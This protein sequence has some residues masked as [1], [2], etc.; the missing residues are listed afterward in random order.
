MPGRRPYANSLFYLHDDQVIEGTL[1][2]FVNLTTLNS[3]F[4]SQQ[5]GSEKLHRN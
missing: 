1:F 2:Y 3:Y 5:L 4:A